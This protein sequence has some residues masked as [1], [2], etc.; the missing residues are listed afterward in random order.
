MVDPE[1]VQDQAVR[2]TAATAVAGRVGESGCFVVTADRVRTGTPDERV[3]AAPSVERGEAGDGADGG[4]AVVELRTESVGILVGEHGERVDD[5]DRALV[6][7]A[8]GIRI[9]GVAH[10][11]G[12][13]VGEE[14]REVLSRLEVEIGGLVRAA[15]G[16]G[17]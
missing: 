16:I 3:A 7:H 9:D 1:F 10:H 15:E 14:E 12:V 2:T 6:E 11:A 8:V 17:R 5:R 13:P 4:V